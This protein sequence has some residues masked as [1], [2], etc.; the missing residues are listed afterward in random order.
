MQS[1]R[2]FFF[3]TIRLCT[4]V[5]AL[6]FALLLTTLYAGRAIAYQPITSV[7]ASLSTTTAARL[8]LSSVG[9]L[10]KSKFNNGLH[11][12]LPVQ[13]QHSSS[14]RSP[15]WAHTNQPDTSMAILGAPITSNGLDFMGRHPL[16][17]IGA[18]ALAAGYFVRR[19]KVQQQ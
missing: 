16:L 14:F 1:P 3:F 5:V 15:C 11:R 10:E 18:Y 4:A 17:V 6:K 12:E 19:K 2:F 13:Q 8:K 9:N 7:P